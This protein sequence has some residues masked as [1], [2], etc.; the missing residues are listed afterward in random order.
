MGRI[1]KHPRPHTV[2]VEP[3]DFRLS[4]LAW[5]LFGL[6]NRVG[7]PGPEGRAPAFLRPRLR[8]VAGNARDASFFGAWVR[9]LGD[10]Q[11][12]E[13]DS[14][15]LPEGAL[16]GVAGVLEGLPFGE[17]RRTA[18]SGSSPAAVSRNRR[19]A[20]RV[21]ALRPLRRKRPSTLCLLP[22]SNAQSQPLSS[23]SVD[24]CSAWTAI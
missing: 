6:R 23:I 19:R 5:S 16:G 9:N 13:V 12:V 11:P 17:T 21:E 24:S 3:I 20:V 4:Q 10:D 1:S 2:S 18:R 14:C 7:P 22:A 15:R 8:S